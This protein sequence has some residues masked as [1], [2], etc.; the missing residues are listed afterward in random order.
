MPWS[1]KICFYFFFVLYVTLKCT[2]K[3]QNIKCF[4][5][6][7]ICEMYNARCVDYLISFFFVI[8]WFTLYHRKALNG[9]T[10]R[11]ANEKKQTKWIC[12]YC[13][14]SDYLASSHTSKYNRQNKNPKSDGMELYYFGRKK[15]NNNKK[16]IVLKK[17]TE[18]AT[19]KNAYRLNII[20]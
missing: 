8:L 20:F 17:N 12:N 16:M 11:W 5:V 19:K 6:F 13:I 18:M 3:Y 7:C 10:G 2:F 15:H 4:A 1:D 9:P 14:R